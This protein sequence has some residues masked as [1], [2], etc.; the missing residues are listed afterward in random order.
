MEI[1]FVSFNQEELSR[2]NKVM[3]LLQGQGAIDELGLGRI[4]DAFSNTMFPGMSTLQTRAKYFLLMPAL[5]AFL[6][7]TRINDAR[8]AR[9]KIR[10]YEILLTRRLKESTSQENSWGIIGAESLDKRDNFVKYDPAYVYHAGMETYGLIKSGGNIYRM[11]AE[12]SAIYRNMPKKQRSNDDSTEDSDDLDGITQIFMTCGEDYGFKSKNPLPVTL[13]RKEAEFLKQQIVVHTSGSLLGYLLDSGLYMSATENKFE[14]LGDKLKDVPSE[15]YH[16]YILGRRYSRFACLLRIRYAM[17]YDLAVGAVDAAH[18][19]EKR[20]FD[21][22]NLHHEEFSTAAIDEI[23][24]FASKRVT[25]ETCRIFIRKAAGLIAE[26][27]WLKLDELIARRE[28]E[29][30]TARRSKLANAKD[31]EQGKPFETPGMMSFRWNTTVRNMLNEIRE[32][33]KNE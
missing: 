3:K 28:M 5:Y 29:I 33:F 7:R 19:E 8:D 17:L 26:N 31:Y 10:Q 27:N 11:L 4:R 14:T 13:T 21:L 20:F 23:L 25:E 30:K 16:K 32:G 9:A 12:R 2:A 24:V 1:G 22:L 6:E 18:Y 15:L